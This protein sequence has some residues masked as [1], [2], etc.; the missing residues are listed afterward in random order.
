VSDLRSFARDTERSIHQPPFE[1]MIAA[2]RRAQRRRAAVTIGAAVAAVLA[3]ALALA[4]LTQLHHEQ[5]P[6]RPAPQLLVPEWKAD[7]IVGHPSA[8]V[9]TR[10]QSLSH[11]GTVLTVWKRCTHPR[12]DHDCLGRE[13]ITV[14]DRAGHRFA[15][16]AAVTGPSQQLAATGDGLLRE[17]DHGLWYWAHTN[18]GPYLLSATMSQPVQLTVG[19]PATRRFGAPSIECPD[20]VGVCTLDVSGRTVQRLAVPDVPDTHWAIPTPIGCGLWGLAGVG[21][22][23]SLVIQQRDGTFATTDLPDNPIGA[24]MAEGGTNCEV[25]YYQGIALGQPQVVVSLDRGKTWQTREARVPQEAGL[26]EQ[27]PRVRVLIPPQWQSLPRVL[28]P[29]PL[30]G[31]LHPL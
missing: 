1:A 27:Q 16:V 19:G 23:L 13:A 22:K 12:P 10:L 21:S 26:V 17:V 28:H 7:Q 6:A 2:R 5:I 15:T 25:A 30:P 3:L 31:P 9:V 14:E 29:V 4:G 8:F 18:P 20:Q 11:A 24:S